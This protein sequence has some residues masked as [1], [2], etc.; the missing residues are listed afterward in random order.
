MCLNREFFPARKLLESWN[1]RVSFAPGR[2]SP[3]HA[4]ADGRWNDHGARAAASRRANRHAAIHHSAICHCART[5]SRLK[6]WI[7]SGYRSGTRAGAMFDICGI[8]FRGLKILA[9]SFRSVTFH[10][11]ACSLKCCWRGPSPAPGGARGVNRHAR[12]APQAITTC[13]HPC[14]PA[15]GIRAKQNLLTPSRQGAKM[16]E[17]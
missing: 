4:A 1:P 3:D 10:K 12:F 2:Q 15:F 16:G 17:G 13:P 11:Q 14:P 8:L 5:L 9:I 7:L 6:S